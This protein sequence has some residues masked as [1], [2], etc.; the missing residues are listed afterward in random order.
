MR[1][2]FQIWCDAVCG[3]VRFRPD[4]KAIALELRAHY[5]DR[6]RDLERLGYEPELAAQRSLA[7]MG[8]AQTVGR[9]LNRVHK[10]WLGWLWEASRGLLL[11]LA[12]LAAVTLFITAGLPQL[13]KRT[14]G[15]LNWTEPPESAEKVEL[16]HAILWAAPGEV[17]ERDG[18][19]VAEVRLWLKMRD[20]LAAECGVSTWRFTY[21]DQQGEVPLEEF[22]F[23]TSKWP[24]SRYWRYTNN[25]SG[26][27]RY[28]HTVEL[29]LD[30]PPRWVEISYPVGGGSWALHLEWEES[31]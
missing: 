7:A 2:E 8:D 18:H 11:G 17:T 28:S 14:R 23:L 29:V 30:A 9:A 6:C 26:W 19:I 20:P 10:P 1:N 21:R 3:C 12:V 27:M 24:E 5:E 4:R 15:E 13:A 31:L 25:S 16:E 22:D